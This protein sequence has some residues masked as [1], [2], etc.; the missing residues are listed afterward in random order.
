MN[1]KY[2]KNRSNPNKKPGRGRPYDPNKWITGPDPLEHDRY[3]AWM[4]HK[5]QAKFR[6]E[7][8]YLTYADWCQI[9]TPDLFVLRGKLADDLCCC[10]I[11]AEEGWH[12]ANVHV[13]TNRWHRSQSPGQRKYK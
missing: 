13:V 8:Y 2:Y 12:L 5:A 10:K 6:N 7:P 9:W 11:V 1:G 4:K 3:Y